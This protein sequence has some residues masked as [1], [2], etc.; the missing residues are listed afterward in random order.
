[1]M[2]NDPPDDESY[3][4]P[5]NDNGNASRPGPEALRKVN[6]VAL[7]LARI[8]GRRMAREDFEKAMLAANDNV[9]SETRDTD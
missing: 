3:P 7:R 2:P 6:A 1:M 5:A 4:V 8:I 9:P